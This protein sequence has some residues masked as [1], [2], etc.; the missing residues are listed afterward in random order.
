MSSISSFTECTQRLKKNPQNPQ[1]IRECCQFVRESGERHSLFIS[2]IGNKITSHSSLANRI[3]DDVWDIYEDVVFAALDVNNIT[4]AKECI[5]RLTQQFGKSSIRVSRLQGLLREAEG[6]IDGAKELY[7]HL[8]EEH[9][10]DR[11]CLRRAIAI[12]RSQGDLTE[13]LTAMNEYLTVFAADAEAFEEMA[14]IYLMAEDEENAVFCLEEVMLA[15][16]EDDGSHVMLAEVLYRREAYVTA[17]QHYAK[18]V[19][20]NHNNIRALFG[21]ILAAENTSDEKADQ[22]IKW[23][24]ERLCIIYE[25]ANNHK[26]ID[27]VNNSF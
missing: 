8:L 2:E 16:P 7:E 3:G 4:L 18:A 11:F 10:T 1:T 5:S 24:K 27:I 15:M 21:L 9:P 20:M 14:E 25:K 19:T 22:L 17:R 23:A 26:M 12:K 13:A 6:D